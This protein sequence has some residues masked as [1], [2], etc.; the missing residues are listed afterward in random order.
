MPSDP[1]RATMHRINWRPFVVNTN[2]HCCVLPVRLAWRNQSNV[3]ARS[4][5]N[6]SSCLRCWWW[7][8]NLSFVLLLLLVFWNEINDGVYQ[9]HQTLLSAHLFQKWKIS[10]FLKW[11]PA[12]CWQLNG[13]Q[14]NWETHF[15]EKK[16]KILTEN[17]FELKT[18]SY[19]RKID[20]FFIAVIPRANEMI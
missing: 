5:K 7:E 15:V 13:C 1:G 17:M 10:R 14:N 16:I 19:L 12:D 11:T 9:T 4:G 6:A 20:E 8:S 3:W 2:D 18:R